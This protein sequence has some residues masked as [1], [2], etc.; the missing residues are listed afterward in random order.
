[1]DFMTISESFAEMLRR[2]Q[3]LQSEL[4][5]A[6]QHIDVIKTRLRTV[7]E[8]SDFRI[9]GSLARGTSIR[10]FSDVDLFA[11]F[12]KRNFTR[13]DRLI[14]SDTALSNIRQELVGR[15]P[16][17]L[18]SK[19]VMAIVVEFSDRRNVDIVPALFDRMHNDKWP[20]YLIPDGAGSWM[21]TCPSLYDAYIA[22]ANRQSGNKL[23]Y[24]AQLM[25]FWRECREPRIPLS[26]FHIEMVLASEGVCKGVKSYGACMLD[27]LRSLA[28]RECRAIQDPYGIAGNIS[29]VKTASQRERALA[30][31]IHSR[32][33]ASS[34]VS[35]ESWNRTEAQRQWDIVFRN[36]FPT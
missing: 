6:Q 24:V 30:S 18:I 15:Y 20:I 21:E 19:D 10:G 36:R 7:F 35:S 34:A 11:I 17:S 29:A 25:K 14:N 13:A 28:R 4:D 33:H 3:P 22:E 16:N 23:A 9:A 8:V 32:D 12:R 26:S 1:V 27:I 5:A 2:I 31:I